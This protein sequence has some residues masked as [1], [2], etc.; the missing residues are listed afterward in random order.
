MQKEELLLDSLDAICEALSLELSNRL[1]VLL[2]NK[3]CKQ[4][5]SGFN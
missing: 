2:L 4:H 5:L 3:L 1:V